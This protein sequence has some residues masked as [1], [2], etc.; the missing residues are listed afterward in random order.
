M[1]WKV[2]LK[3]KIIIVAL[4]LVVALVS[5]RPKDS[6]NIQNHNV[7][8]APYGGS[9]P[10]GPSNSGFGSGINRHIQQAM[11]NMMKSMQGRMKYEPNES[12]YQPASPISNESDEGADIPAPGKPGDLPPYEI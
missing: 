9:F 10:Y 2:S 3:M 1:N 7:V 8:G 11:E 12:G 4:V 5:A 6:I